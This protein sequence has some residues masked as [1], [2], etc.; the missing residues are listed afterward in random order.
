MHPTLARLDRLAER[1]SRDPDVVAVLGVG[2]AGAE[3]DRF[4]DHSDIDVFVVVGDDEAARRYADTTDWLTGFGG[5]PAHTFVSDRH[6]RK[7][8]FHDGLFVEYAVFTA[9]ELPTIPFVGERVVW[10]RDGFEPVG[11]RP[12]V[13][14][15][16]DRVEVHLNEALSNL[17]VGLHRELR[18]ERLTATRFIQ[19]YAVDRVLALRRLAPGT[20]QVQPDAFEP[21]RRVERGTADGVPLSAMIPGYDRNAEGAA[22]TLAWLRAHHEPAEVMVAAIER[23]LRDVVDA[24]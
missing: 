3:A 5:S 6:G 20:V 16:L 8:L 7:A 9:A 11:R 17:F 19:V 22:A 24:R 13:A 1:L 18:G 14:P 10:C 23:L 2:S 4:D 15:D 12:G 21:T